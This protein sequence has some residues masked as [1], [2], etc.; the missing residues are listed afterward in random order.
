MCLELFGSRMH[1]LELIF[2][3]NNIQK[4]NDR[5]FIKVMIR[6]RTFSKVGSKIVRI[7]NNGFQIL[8]Y[9]STSDHVNR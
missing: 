1:F 8:Y 3:K 4:K 7:R 9:M 5:K 2:G 6:I